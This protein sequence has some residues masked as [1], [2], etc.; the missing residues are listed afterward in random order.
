MA[1]NHPKGQAGYPGRWWIL[2]AVSFSLFLGSTD[3]SIVNV[4]LPTL[5]KE[6]SADFATIQWV[7]L[8]YLFALYLLSVPLVIWHERRAS[9][10]TMPATAPTYGRWI[11]Q[12]SWLPCRTNSGCTSGLY[13]T[14]HRCPELATRIGPSPRVPAQQPFANH[15]QIIWELNHAV[16]VCCAV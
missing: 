5:M 10:P 4:A 9:H 12:T 8:G 13:C 2:T 7:V 1:S 15:R 11:P 14:D 3:G 6:L 16:P